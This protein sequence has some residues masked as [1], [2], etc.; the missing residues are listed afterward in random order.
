MARQVGDVLFYGTFFWANGYIGPDGK[1][2]MRMKSPGMT[3]KQLRNGKSELR[4][5]CTRRFGETSK[6][7]MDGWRWVPKELRALA[8]RYASQRMVGMLM[9]SKRGDSVP[10]GVLSGMSLTRDAVAESD[11]WV[12]V[13]GEDRDFYER[14]CRLPKG[15]VV[16]G[17]E[18][19]EEMLPKVRKGKLRVRVHVHVG[20][21]GPQLAYD[22]EGAHLPQVRHHHVT[23]WVELDE[24]ESLCRVSLD[25]KKILKGRKTGDVLVLLGVEVGHVWGSKIVSLQCASRLWVAWAGALESVPKR[26]INRGVRR[27]R[28]PE[29]ERMQ[30]RRAPK[31]R[32]A[33]K[34][35]DGPFP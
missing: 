8:D 23:E 31:L 29:R 13:R 2:V 21:L 9:P 4:R 24:V 14:S 18:S 16:R 32:V 30:S 7:V 5:I 35:R 25:W 17:I 27:V 3:K 20:C 33:L 11:M 34:G 10:A 6:H 1:G 26:R 15:F 19:M 28:V 12:D 22:A